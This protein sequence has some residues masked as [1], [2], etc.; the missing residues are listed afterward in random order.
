MSLRTFNRKPGLL[1]RAEAS[2]LIKELSN[3][4]RRPA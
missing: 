3:L 1:T 2:S 4:T